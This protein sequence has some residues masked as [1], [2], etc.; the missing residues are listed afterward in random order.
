MSL[1]NFVVV[2]V[3]LFALVAW[4]LA[5]GPLSPGFPPLPSPR[6]C[7]LFLVQSV[8]CLCFFVFGLWLRLCVWFAF[9]RGETQIWLGDFAGRPAWL[10]CF[11][12]VTIY[13]LCRT[14]WVL[15]QN[16]LLLMLM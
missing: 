14:F 2:A 6:G 9:P 5:V 3:L 10:C 12:F 4:V 15:V 1:I 7:L 13:L 11:W 8:F 16:V